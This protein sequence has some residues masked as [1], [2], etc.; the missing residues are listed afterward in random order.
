MSTVIYK[1]SSP[2]YKTIQTTW[3]LGILEPRDILRDGTDVYQLLQNKYEF[4]PD[5]L[6]YDTYGTPNYWW[7]FM[8]VNQDLIVD[9][10]YD[11][12]AG[13]GIYVPTSARLSAVL[14]G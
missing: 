4:R 1:P 8:M 14:G 7:V 13:L 2:Y 11:F 9:P 10:I 6:A 5:L 3:Y 12:T